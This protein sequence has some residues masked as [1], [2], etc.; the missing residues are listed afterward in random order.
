MGGIPGGL[1]CAVLASWALSIHDFA[2]CAGAAAAAAAAACSIQLAP[3]F[4]GGCVGCFGPPR[5]IRSWAN[6]AAAS[7]PVCCHLGVGRVSCWQAQLRPA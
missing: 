7:S 3:L 6:A 1:K 2:G 4:A 5:C